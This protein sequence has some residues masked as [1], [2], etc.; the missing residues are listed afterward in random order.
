MGGP[1][2]GQKFVEGFLV[3]DSGLMLVAWVFGTMRLMELR[4]GLHKFIMAA[5]GGVVPS[6]FRPMW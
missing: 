4:K 6:N 5:N 1:V 2:D 3:V